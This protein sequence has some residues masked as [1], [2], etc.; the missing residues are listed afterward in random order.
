[1]TPQLEEAERLLRLARRDRAVFDAVVIASGDMH[2]AAGFHAQ[3][4]VEKALKG[5]CCALDLD[6]PRTHDL[7]AL[8]HLLQRHGIALPAS[9]ISLRALTPYAVDFRYDAEAT[10]L[11]TEAE[12][13]RLADDVLAFAAVQI[14]RLSRAG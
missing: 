5:L 2:A 13:A 3:Q 11:M 1:M 6:F 12:M 4:A 14:E 9:A 7:D 8:S 10:Q